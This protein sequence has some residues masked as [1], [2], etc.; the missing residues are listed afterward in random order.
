MAVTLAAGDGLGKP[1]T[2]HNFYVPAGGDVPDPELNPKFAHKLAFLDEVTAWPRLL[3][4]A[5]LT[6]TP[7]WWATSTSLPLKPTWNHRQLL[8]EPHAGGGGAHGA[9]AGRR[10]LGG[11]HAR[12]RA[13]PP[14]QKLFTWW[15]YRSPDYTVND[16]GR[17]LDPRV[18]Q[19]LPGAPMPRP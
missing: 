3:E 4:D 8:R 14:E 16:R 17:R 15:S 9:L 7:C 6:A 10:P 11:H 12:L 1:L 2:I 19:P 18:G 5:A 13:L